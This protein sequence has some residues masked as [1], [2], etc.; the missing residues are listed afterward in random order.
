MFNCLNYCK[1]MDI[2]SDDEL[3]ESTEVLFSPAK[4]SDAIG[5]KLV[6]VS[7]RIQKVWIN[8]QIESKND[9]HIFYRYFVFVD[10]NKVS[11]VRG[12][13]RRSDEN[14]KFVWLSLKMDQL[15]KSNLNQICS[16][17]SSTYID[18]K[19][20]I[21]IS[22]YDTLILNY[23]SQFLETERDQIELSDEILW[24]VCP[25]VKS[26][27]Q[28]RKEFGLVNIAHTTAIN[29]TKST[30]QWETL[31]CIM[32]SEKSLLES[33]LFAFHLNSNFQG[34]FVIGIS[35]QSGCGKNYVCQSI[36][37][38]L[39]RHIINFDENFV[40]S[41]STDKKHFDSFMFLVEH[42]TANEKKVIKN[43]LTLPIL[44]VIIG[45]DFDRVDYIL[46]LNLPSQ[47]ANTKFTDAI[48]PSCLIEKCSNYHQIQTCQ[49][50]IQM[51]NQIPIDQSLLLLMGEQIHYTQ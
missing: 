45:E 35:G 38:M 40:D 2:L 39:G 30:E 1:V 19:M 28:K 25:F 15:Q 23:R 49:K 44:I 3:T 22:S 37:K 33:L 14:E 20:N 31:N 36:A 12:I 34:S 6:F 17:M 51:N 41:N 9:T 4:E 42:P 7:D 10:E 27:S 18:S 24:C 50:L 46:K 32:E 26:Y 21:K 11:S 43:L 13:L 29:I 8:A 47:Q 5:I 48:I 16:T